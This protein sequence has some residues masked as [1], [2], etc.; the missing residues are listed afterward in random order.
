MEIFYFTLPQ[1]FG[2]YSNIFS[3]LLRCYKHNNLAVTFSNILASCIDLGQGELEIKAFIKSLTHG[4]WWQSAGLSRCE[5]IVDSCLLKWQREALQKKRAEEA[6]MMNT[7]MWISKLR[8]HANPCSGHLLKFWLTQSLRYLPGISSTHTVLLVFR[9]FKGKSYFV[10]LPFKTE[11][12][13]GS[14]VIIS[15]PFHSPSTNKIK[16]NPKPNHQ[17]NQNPKCTFFTK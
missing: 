16:P 9:F 1:S 2:F 17:Q 10:W 7:K 13:L 6:A 8:I 11:I 5:K 3:Y 4:M 15:T 14:R 12:F